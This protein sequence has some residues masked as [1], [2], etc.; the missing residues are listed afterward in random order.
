MATAERIDC[1]TPLP[2]D[3]ATALLTEML[4]PAPY[5]A[6]EKKAQKKGQTGR[7]GLHHKGTSDVTFGD[8]ETHSSPATKDE[9]EEEQSYSPP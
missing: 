1:P 6:P 2:E 5:Q 8:A 9:E 3:P 4:V 7:G